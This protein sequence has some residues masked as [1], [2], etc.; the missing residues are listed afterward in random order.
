[1]TDRPTGGE[2]KVLELVRVKPDVSGMLDVLDELRARVESGDV[3]AFAVAVDLA[4]EVW[5]RTAYVELDR[6]RMAGILDRLKWHLHEAGAS[7]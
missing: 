7:E 6:F 5:L 4:D 3:L 2:G 1:M